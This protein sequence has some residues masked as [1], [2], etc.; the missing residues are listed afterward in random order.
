M[1]ITV[2][3]RLMRHIH[4]HNRRHHND[5]TSPLF[6]QSCVLGQVLTC[7]TTIYA[8]QGTLPTLADHLKTACVSTA[9]RGTV[10]SVL[11]MKFIAL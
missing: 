7:A 6:K 11:E 3:S 2:A 8:K 4:S 9:Y 10:A 5:N 1:G